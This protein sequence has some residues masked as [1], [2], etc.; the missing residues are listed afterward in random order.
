LIVAA[1][2]DRRPSLPTPLTPLV[3]R[4]REIA[5]VCA[6]LRREDVRLVTLTGPGGTG[7][8]RL[9]IAVAERLRDDFADGVAFVTLQAI[10]DPALVL[11]AIAQALDVREAAD[12]PLSERLQAA[13]RRQQLLLVLDNFEQLL[14]AGPSIAELLGACPGLTM[15][16]TSRVVLNVT[17]E[18]DVYVPPLELPDSRRLPPV[19]QLANVEAVRLFVERARAARSGFALT[20][21]DAPA[22]AAI[23]ARLD[24]LPL[25]VELAAARMRMLSPPALLPLLDQRLRVLTGGPRDAPARQRTMRDTIAWSVDLLSADERRLFRQVS[26]FAGGWTLEAAGAV[27]VPGQDALDRVATLVDHSLVRRVEQPDGSVRFVMLE[28]I[29]EYGWRQLTERGEEEPILRRHAEFY[30]RL[31]EMADH[32]LDAGDELRR[33]EDELANL[34]VALGWSIDHDPELG[35][36]LAGAL[37]SFWEYGS[38]SEGRRWLELALHRSEAVTPAARARALLAAGRLATDQGDYAR[39][40]TLLEEC[41]S[42][43]RS[44]GNQSAPRYVSFALGRIAMFEG[45]FEQA[46]RLNEESLAIARELGLTIL[47]GSTYRNLGATAIGAGD[48]DRARE[49]FEQSIELSRDAQSRR[50]PATDPRPE[51]VPLARLVVGGAPDS[52]RAFMLAQLGHVALERRDV[53]RAVELIAESLELARVGGHQRF[54]VQCL[55]KLAWLM[56]ANGRPERAAN[57]LGLIANLRQAIGVPVPPILQIDYDRY[58][59]IAKAQLGDAAW[60]VAWETGRSMSLDDAI[61]LMR[62]PEPA[63]VAASA[64]SALS[65][66][67]QREVE[68]LHLLVEGHSNKEIGDALSISPNTVANHVTNIMN[69]LGLDSRTAVATWAMRHGVT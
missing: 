42:L 51:D 20:S 2:P 43:Y 5:A 33:L 3:G 65:L 19:E 10:V 21:E 47:I 57:V 25:A 7:K 53:A 6:L 45:D 17:G 69:K 41:Q 52:A 29:R 1:S 44:L 9:A 48:Y 66:L 58:I 55:E 56:I 22:V 50:V 46:N 16:V 14:P 31:A 30:L 36:R 26:V 64:G 68:V 13:L 11:P 24:G 35:V 18:H 38:P 23:C 15:L 34:R 28:T 54:T 32:A 40:R 37:D 63:P 61:A 59:P 4:E 39:A 49:F 27:C 67:S 60:D 62:L 12:Q 8:T